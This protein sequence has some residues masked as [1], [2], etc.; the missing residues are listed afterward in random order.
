MQLLR[1]S[2]REMPDRMPC[3]GQAV[4]PQP[5]KGR[6][7]SARMGFPRNVSIQIFLHPSNSPALTKPTEDSARARMHSPV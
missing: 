5:G 7:T 4:S 1:N 6:W 2:R 3:V